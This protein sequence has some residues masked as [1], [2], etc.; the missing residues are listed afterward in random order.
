MP[1]GWK[2][3]IDTDEAEAEL[4]KLRRELKGLGVDVKKVEGGSKK[5]EA[6][7]RKG[8][9]AE[10]AEKA[11]DHLKKSMKLTSLEISKL[12]AKSGN[13]RGAFGT[14]S[15][16]MKGAVS[17]AMKLNVAFAALGAGFSAIG[18]IKAFATFQSA[19]I[20]MGKVTDESFSKIQTKIQE[21]DEALGSSTDLVKAYYQVISAGVTEPV[22]AMELLIVSAKASKAAHSD[23]AEL[24]KGLAA[25]MGAYGDTIK[26]VSV[27]SDLLFQIEASG[28][29]TVQ[30][31]IPEMGNLSAVSA[32]VG[33]SMN[34]M[35]AALARVSQAGAGTS[36]AATQ[37]RS[38]LFGMINPS[39]EMT[40][41]FKDYG[42]AMKAIKK[43]GFE[44]T[45]KVMA[46]EIGSNEEALMKLI[47]RKEGVMGFLQLM[48]GGFSDYLRI[49]DDMDDAIGKTEKAYL[50]YEHTIA[51]VWHTFQATIKNMFIMVGEDLAPMAQESIENLS[52]YIKQNKEE[53]L[54]FFES[55]AHLMEGLVTISG[56]LATSIGWLPKWASDLGA[57]LALAKAGYADFWEV[58]NADIFSGE[59]SAVV[60][61]AEARMEIASE[62]VIV[63]REK[64][65]KELDKITPKLQGIGIDSTTKKRMMELDGIITSLTKKIVHLQFIESERRAAGAEAVDKSIE[66]MKR[67][68]KYLGSG[69]SDLLPE[70]HWTAYTK[71]AARA[72]KE[73]GTIVKKTAR[74]LWNEQL[75][76]YAAMWPE[77]LDGYEEMK[78]KELLAALE[79]IKEIEDATGE[80]ANKKAAADAAAILKAQAD[81]LK[82]TEQRLEDKKKLE[83]KA[84]EDQEKIY[85]NMLESI[86]KKTAD[87]FY[88]IFDD[89]GKGWDTLLDHM[90]DWFKKFL[91]ELAAAAIMKPIII[92]MIGAATSFLGG[93]TAAASGGGGGGSGLLSGASAI[94]SQTGITDG[95]MESTGITGLL[96]T[97]MWTTPAAVQGLS[98][99]TALQLGE[100][101]IGGPGVTTPGMGPSYGSALTAGVLGSLGYATIGD[102]LGLPQS[103]W[104]GLGAGL[105]SSL[106]F[107]GGVAAAGTGGILAGMELGAWAGPIGAVIGAILGGLLGSLFGDDPSQTRIGGDYSF[108]P[109]GDRELFDMALIDSIADDVSAEVGDSALAAIE[110]TA[111]TALE[112]FRMFYDILGYDQKAMVDEAVEEFTTSTRASARTG[113]LDKRFKNQLGKLY[114]NIQDKVAG[115]F[116]DAINSFTEDIYSELL[117]AGAGEYSIVEDMFKGL[118]PLISGADT[119]DVINYM[120]EL[121][122]V[123]EAVSTILDF[124]KQIKIMTGEVTEFQLRIEE[125][126]AVF[127]QIT[128]IFESLGASAEKLAWVENQ[129]VK[130]LSDINDEEKAARVSPGLQSWLDVRRYISDTAFGI[131]TST[132]NPQNNVARL[133]LIKDSIDTFTSNLD[134]DAITPQDIQELTGMWSDY[135]GA[136]GEVYQRPS[137]EYQDIYDKVMG[138]FEYLGAFADIK[139]VEE[140]SKEA[141]LLSDQLTV[142]LSIEEILGQQYTIF[143][144]IQDQGLDPAKFGDSLILA[145][146]KGLITQEDFDKLSLAT[147]NAAIYNAVLVQEAIDRAADEF[148]YTQA[149]AA[150]DAAEMAYVNASFNPDVTK[151][152]WEAMPQN[153]QDALM[154]MLNSVPIVDWVTPALAG[155]EIFYQTVAGM[156]DWIQKFYPDL[157]MPDVYTDT[158][159]LPLSYQG[160]T[161]YVPRTGQYWLHEGE[162]VK[163]AHSGEGG[164]TI[165]VEIHGAT[166][167]EATGA[168]VTRA[169][170]DYLESPSA[171]ARIQ[172]AAKGYN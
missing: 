128:Y 101:G 104:S 57:G 169:L 143:S 70:E 74:E 21:M 83:E 24:V 107:A 63:M 98:G 20:D 162:T 33:L 115:F 142:L 105:G 19:L 15:K 161:E 12:Q 117:A 71:S 91:S 163:Q 126:N 87:V 62:A 73:T 93:G 79:T 141:G 120:A 150:H 139:G 28:I 118:T 77:Y 96:S 167:P 90:K 23:Q 130:I 54:D 100:L 140:I 42:G 43:I 159:Q 37:L 36:M 97:P 145:L 52:K 68:Y 148:T 114:D 111:N 9:G 7:M 44:E 99:T 94:A 152:E 76:E 56:I 160:G 127:D 112:G 25:V 1:G 30:Q 75:K 170:D 78:E 84:A 132:A 81:E 46:E 35:G 156:A 41:L 18:A 58:M 151:E 149:L 55:M 82:A 133:G 153:L 137:T 66:E 108:S 10:K 59:L 89:V 3:P 53:I 51:G 67:S 65:V 6:R 29:T 61:A 102:W 109:T 60:A 13:L 155:A 31:L 45:M 22:A 95:L 113:D 135:L 124:E 144:W 165:N 14:L 64:Y 131:S 39:K 88:D 147:W 157:T 11:I 26:D 86:Q 123:T 34:E 17:L 158:P 138:A 134:L 5:L 164:F 125:T 40:A 2:V 121:G 49:L 48:K 106:G 146:D 168:A 85:F 103:E 136:A 27:A 172:S 72:Y 92:P 110:G 38:L 129:R 80:A 69:I 4:K 171:R 8:M 154:T 166:Q 47:G 16:S 50:D 32:N 122:E 116:V 119:E